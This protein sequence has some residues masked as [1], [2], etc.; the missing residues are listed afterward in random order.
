[1]NLKSG[2]DDKTIKAN[3]DKLMKEGYSRSQA[4]RL[5]FEYAKT[6]KHSI[7]RKGTNECD[8]LSNG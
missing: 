4:I 1:M 3:I 6:S 8:P 5:A 2:S 7:S